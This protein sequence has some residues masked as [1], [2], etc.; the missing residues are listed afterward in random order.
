MKKFI[1][2]LSVTLMAIT[3][4]FALSTSAIR[5]NARFLTDRM[6]WELDMTPRQYEDCYEINYDFI[7]SINHIMK[8]VAYG[9]TDAIDMYYTY[10]DYRNDDL[11]YILTN[12][13]YAKFLTLDYF[14]RPIYTY[15]GDWMF[16]V[17]QVYNNR[18]FFYFDAPTIYRSYNGSHGR[19]HHVNGFYGNNRYSH[20]IAPKY[21]S[22]RGDK[23]YGNHSR[24][25]F[26]QNRRDRNTGHMTNGYNNRN[27]DN[28]ER[29]NRYKDERKGQNH[30]TPEI[31]NRNNHGNGQGAQPGQ[32]NGN[33]GNAG[34]SNHGNSNRGNGGH[35]SA[36]N[37]KQP[38]SA[39]R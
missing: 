1:I 32:N 39:R 3:N 5:E 11:H 8:E 24:N 35:P 4:A 33:H 36:G 20:A 9:Y 22:L 34:N 13:Q 31:N 23:N 29:D 2:T 26:G 6:A 19:K 37:N 7:Y 38:G 16:R 15:R 14:Y 12:H 10:L 25:D 27:Q 28:R 30:N 18:K 17:Y 21:G